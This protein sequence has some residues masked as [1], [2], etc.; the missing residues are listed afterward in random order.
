M[1]FSVSAQSR[2]DA[3]RMQL[4]ALGRRE[5]ARFA[6]APCRPTQPV[7]VAIAKPI[8]IATKLPQL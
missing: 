1:S 2:R 7:A 8:S 3:A 5:D 4:A 6:E